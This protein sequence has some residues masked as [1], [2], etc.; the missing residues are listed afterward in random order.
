M[1]WDNINKYAGTALLVQAKKGKSHNNIP[2]SS[3]STKKELNLLG[4][5]PDFLLSNQTY[6]KSGSNPKPYSTNHHCEFSLSKSVGPYLDHCTFL[7]IKD[8]RSK[9]WP[10]WEPPWQTMWP[11][12]SNR[13]SYSETLINM[14]SGFSNAKGKRFQYGSF[15]NDWDGLITLLIDETLSLVGG[16]AKGIKQNTITPLHGMNKNFINYV[17]HGS[18]AGDK[19]QTSNPPRGISTIFFTPIND[20]ISDD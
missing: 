1:K 20:E 8:A 10:D 6:I 2:I 12:A 13:D 4:N 3:P 11:P 16:T 15:G 17:Y 14:V 7:Q 18:T 5:L 9:K 19:Q